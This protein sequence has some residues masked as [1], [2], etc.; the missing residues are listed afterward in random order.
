M[1]KQVI[2][3][4]FYLNQ[5]IGTEGTFH[6]ISKNGGVNIVYPD[7]ALWTFHPQLVTKV[8]LLTMHLNH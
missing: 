2:K 7:K 8:G 6:S 1:M 4:F 5:Y 3:D